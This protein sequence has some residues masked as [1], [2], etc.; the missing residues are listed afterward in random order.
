MCEYAGNISLDLQ[1]SS[2]LA[3]IPA[4]GVMYYAYKTVRFECQ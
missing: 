3:L 4:R 2:I 1:S